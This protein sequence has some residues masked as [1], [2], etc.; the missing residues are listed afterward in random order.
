[1]KNNDFTAAV[2]VDQA[3][4]KVFNAINNVRGWWSENIEGKTDELNGEFTHRDRYLNV[5]FKITQ[6]TPQKIVWDIVESHC[7]M[8]LENIHEWEGTRI[9]FEIT[10]K[11]GKTEIKFTHQGLSP[12]FECYKVC[13]K[14]WSFFITTSLKDLIE[15]GKGD[16]ISNE[17][18]SFT[19]AVM[20]DKSPEEVFAAVKNV[21]GWW[22]NNIEG[23]TDKLND[24]FKFYVD[25][26]LQFHFKII[27]LVPYKRIVWIV[28]D[29]SFGN[30]EEQEWKGTTVLFEISATGGQT[31]LRFTH[32]G[33]VP[34][35]ECYEV[36]HYAW[37]QYI[38]VSLFDFIK[39]GEG[40][41]NKW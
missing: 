14:A 8:F 30:T 18:A 25:K 4:E 22:L 38:Q 39:K 7:N 31:R 17:Y 5:T 37:T 20:V 10:R 24:E 16:P 36:C 26:R 35:L 19:T 21:R 40:Q 23:S 34:S 6:L 3:P 12:E 2:Q 33:L 28:L 41:P 11:A 29:Q 32:Q 15:T 27:E 1:M 9:V 13:S